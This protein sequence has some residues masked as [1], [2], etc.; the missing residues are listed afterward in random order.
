MTEQ[1]P[2]LSDKGWNTNWILT[3]YCT[4]QLPGVDRVDRI[5]NRRAMCIVC[6][7][8]NLP[9]DVYHVNY[10]LIRNRL[11]YMQTQKMAYLRTVPYPWRVPWRSPKNVNMGRN[12]DCL[13]VVPKTWMLRVN[14]VSTKNASFT[15]T[16]WTMIGGAVR[17]DAIDNSTED[18]ERRNWFHFCDGEKGRTTHST[19]HLSLGGASRRVSCVVRCGR[20]Y[21]IYVYSVVQH[22]TRTM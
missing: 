11:A 22:I 21:T 14:G 18:W 2:R 12:M 19:R 10:W 6:S 16:F 20:T 4:L 3:E 7:L 17:V 8:A 1:G 5:I 15:S 13:P 9:Y